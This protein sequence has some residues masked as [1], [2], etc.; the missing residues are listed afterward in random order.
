MDFFDILSTVIAT[1]IIVLFLAVFLMW[2][3]HTIKIFSTTPIKELGGLEIAQGAMAIAIV[4]FLLGG[5]FIR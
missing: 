1:P 3:F 2:I 4:S 5:V